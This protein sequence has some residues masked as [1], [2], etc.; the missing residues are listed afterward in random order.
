[1][2]R[3]PFKIPDAKTFYELDEAEQRM[4]L[5]YELIRQSEEYEILSM[6]MGVKRKSENNNGRPTSGRHHGR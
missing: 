5:A 1:M 4:L 6:Q 3:F 2:E